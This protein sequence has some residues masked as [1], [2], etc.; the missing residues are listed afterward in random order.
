MGRDV[1][2]V[3]VGEGEEAGAEGHDFAG[4]DLFAVGGEAVEEFLSHFFGH[5]ASGGY[6]LGEEGGEPADVLLLGRVIVGLIGRHR[7]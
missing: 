2:A 4:E 7:L 5:V 1:D 3:A 6:R